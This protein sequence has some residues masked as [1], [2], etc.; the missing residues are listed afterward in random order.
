MLKDV[1]PMSARTDFKE[2]LRRQRYIYLAVLLTPV[3]GI[4]VAMILI[5]FL[6]H[7]KLGLIMLILGLIL[8]QYL[9]V[10]AYIWMRMFS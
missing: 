9:G 5:S 2:V 3:I 6:G 7:P 8:V 4:I 10:V 1:F